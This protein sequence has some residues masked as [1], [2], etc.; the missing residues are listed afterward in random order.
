MAVR[1][2]S[3]L[4][5]ATVGLVVLGAILAIALLVSSERGRTILK[6]LLIV[7]ALALVVA[8]LTLFS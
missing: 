1:S 2:I 7:P 3:L 8:L 6:V 5:A 4:M